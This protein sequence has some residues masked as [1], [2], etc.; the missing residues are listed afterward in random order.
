[1]DQNFL[2]NLTAKYLYDLHL[3]ASNQLFQMFQGAPSCLDQ[4]VNADI[5]A[6]YVAEVTNATYIREVINAPKASNN[7]QPVWSNNL[8]RVNLNQD[9][10]VGYN[11]N[12]LKVIVIGK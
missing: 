9:Y 5:N 12:R 10:R 7:Y 11:R 1:M 8:V 3:G 4:N 6:P 2:L